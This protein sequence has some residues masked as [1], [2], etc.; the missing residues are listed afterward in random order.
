MVD[1]TGGRAL[2]LLSHPKWEDS[3]VNREMLRAVDDLSAVSIRHLDSLYP[4]FQIDV[5]AEQEAVRC[6]QLIV[7]QHPFYWY[8]SPP[9][10]KQWI[11]C[12]LL[13]GFAFGS[14]TPETRAKTCWSVVTAGGPKEAY[15]PGGFNAYPIETFLFPFERT[16]V[17]CKM[18][19]AP[20]L[21]LHDAYRADQ[22]TIRAHSSRYR[23]ELRRLLSEI[24]MPTVDGGDKGSRDEEA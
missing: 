2:I 17:F 3:V 24:E 20:P 21:I 23:N 18:K 13:R 4:D 6:H 1:S 10:L 7:F 19:Y 16:A 22:E 15:G 5:D 9:L 8:S 11:D 12:V 14:R